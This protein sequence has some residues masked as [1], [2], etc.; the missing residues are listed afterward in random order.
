MKKT[1]SSED[2]NVLFIP[3]SAIIRERRGGGE[4]TVR[5]REATCIFSISWNG[6]SAFFKLYMVILDKEPS[7]S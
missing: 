2:I 5:H 3:N 6:S 7:R 1:I 4:I